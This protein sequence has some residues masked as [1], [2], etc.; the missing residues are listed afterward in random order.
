VP[1][2]TER[3][4]TAAALRMAIRTKI[5]SGASGRS[6]SLLINSFAPPDVRTDRED[7]SG[8]QRLAVEVIP[9]RHRVAFLEA[10]DQ[11]ADVAPAAMPQVS[12]L[13]G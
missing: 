6:I 8:V 2:I 5:R 12:R 7:S 4:I 3:V 9:H 11:L 10:L 13:V 1:E